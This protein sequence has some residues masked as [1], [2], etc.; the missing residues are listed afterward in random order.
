M[1]SLQQ[2]ARAQL[3]SGASISLITA[4]LATTLKAPRVPDSSL[5]IAG[6]GGVL[7]SPYS[8]ELTLIGIEGETLPVQAQVVDSIPR[9][10]SPEDVQGLKKLPF[11]RGLHLADPNYTPDS[12]IDILLDMGLSNICLREGVLHSTPPGLKAENTIFGWSVGGTASQGVKGGAVS[13]TCLK[14]SPAEDDTDRLLQRFC[15]PSEVF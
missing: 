2:K 1:G 7:H 13:S 5:C 12:R 11:L 9:T 15:E 8:V 10:G 3:D 4:C 6:V 14:A